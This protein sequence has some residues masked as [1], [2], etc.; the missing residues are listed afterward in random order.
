[1]VDKPSVLGENIT[2]QIRRKFPIMNAL[3][4][5]GIGKQ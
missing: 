4:L 2:E 3:I 1:M 5:R